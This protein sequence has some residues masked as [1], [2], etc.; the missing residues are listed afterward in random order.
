LV[1]TTEGYVR[2]YLLNPKEAG[3]ALQGPGTDP[4]KVISELD[5]QLKEL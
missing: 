1:I 2:G 5:K 4:N 3:G